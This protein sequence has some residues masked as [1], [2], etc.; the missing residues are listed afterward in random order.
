MGG[1]MSY[2]KTAQI[3]PAHY[4]LGFT[5]ALEAHYNLGSEEVVL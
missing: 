4:N 2:C 1:S 3:T 5:K